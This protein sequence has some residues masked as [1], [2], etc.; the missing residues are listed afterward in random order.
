MKQFVDIFLAILGVV[1]MIG[2]LKTRGFTSR[3]WKKGDPIHPITTTGRV[4][5]FPIGVASLLAS[6]G[7]ISK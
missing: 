7:V 3:G 6:L 1:F 2:A 4:I 5:L